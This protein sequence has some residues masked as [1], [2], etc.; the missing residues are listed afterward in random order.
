[1]IHSI[2]INHNTKVNAS[3]NLLPRLKDSYT[4]LAVAQKRHSA[5]K[6]WISMLVHTA[7]AS[8]FDLVR[9]TLACGGAG[10]LLAGPCPRRPAAA[11]AARTR[12]PTPCP[13]AK[14]GDRYLD[15]H[16]GWRDAGPL[17]RFERGF[18]LYPIWREP[19]LNLEPSKN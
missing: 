1:M 18:E 15:A 16:F 12:T 8:E 17:S 10:S 19:G 5:D 4:I 13:A 11:A 3:A 2:Q 14:L 7:H 9:D 6:L